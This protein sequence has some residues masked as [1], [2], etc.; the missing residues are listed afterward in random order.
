[1]RE[2]KEMKKSLPLISLLAA[3]LVPAV[4]PCDAQSSPPVSADA[5]EGSF[6]KDIHFSIGEKVWFATW[7][8][9]VLN[10]QVVQPAGG[11]SVIATSFVSSSSSKVMAITSASLSSG[12]FF[13]STSFIPAVRFSNSY[14]VSSKLERREYDTS[15]G[16]ALSPN[17]TAAIIYKG[18]KINGAYSDSVSTF[19][20]AQGE[21]KVTA[22][23]AGISASLN[24]S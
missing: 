6:F 15:L 7:D 23:G 12:S 13:L 4:Q 2:E 22:W 10:A 3:T 11:A 18:G 17:V 8:A 19:L 5:G 21:L 1:V 14:S 9:P 24:I 20:G 16:Y